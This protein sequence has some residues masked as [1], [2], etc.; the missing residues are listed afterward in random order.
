[1]AYVNDQRSQLDVAV[2]L[3]VTALLACLLTVCLLWRDGIWLLLA[4]PPYA[5]AYLSYRGA[6]IAARQ[7]GQAVAV[8]IALNRFALYERLRLPLP[9]T[10]DSERKAAD[11]LSKL[12]SFEESFTATYRHPN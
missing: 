2:R 8:V 12:L 1:M 10:A 5:I 4:L 3:N 6:I 9:A 11:N 7:Y